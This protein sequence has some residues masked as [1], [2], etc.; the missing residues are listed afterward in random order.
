MSVKIIT[1]SGCDLPKNILEQYDIELLSLGVHLE[2]KNYLDGVDLEPKKLYDKMREGKVATTS[3]VSPQTFME[4][5][6]KHAKNNQSCI[7]I[8]FSSQLSGTYETSEMIFQQVKEEYPDF[9]L[10]IIDTKCASLGD[11]LVVY[12]AAQMAKE[13]KSK[14]EILESINF[15]K[16][17]VEH[18]F[19]VDDL[20]YLFRGGRVSKTAAFLGT[21]LNIKPLLDVEDGKLIPREKVRGRKKVL[22]RLVKIMGERGV[23]LKNQL[24][25][26]SHGDDEKGALQL[27]DMIQ[28]E[29]GCED[30]LINM[31]GC[32]IGA[33]SGPGTISLFFLNKEE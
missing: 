6:T 19:T 12:K 33:H 1:D 27:R 20:E 7:Y 3:Q 11:G 4:V 25:A 9:D 14:E 13:G 16:E 10:D 24:I 22:K 23:N 17:H 8:A 15:Y 32:A 30:F 5:F 18:V 21:L 31:I 29:Y 28:E 26:I 2:D